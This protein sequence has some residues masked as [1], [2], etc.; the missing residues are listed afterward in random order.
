MQASAYIPIQL[1]EEFTLTEDIIF[2]INL[3]ILVET[4][5][6]FWPSI[7]SQGSSVTLELH[8]KV[9]YHYIQ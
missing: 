4:L 5:S 3:N 6:M 9:Q 7:N 1:F 2:R 8:Y